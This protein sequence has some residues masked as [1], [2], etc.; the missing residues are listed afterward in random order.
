MLAVADVSSVS[1]SKFLDGVF[2]VG[3]KDG[4]VEMFRKDDDG[5]V[6]RWEGASWNVDGQGVNSISVQ[7][8]Y[9][10]PAVF[11]VLV[12][13]RLFYVDLMDNDVSAGIECGQD[14]GPLRGKIATFATTKG[15]K[16]VGDVWLVFGGEDGVGMRALSDDM[17]QEVSTL[18]DENELEWT[19][20]WLAS[21]VF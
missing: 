14:L 3:R 2:L 1:F 6:M 5:V 19:K 21:A 12:G 18:S 15:S 10:R 4:G 20:L 8:S 13:D 16:R 11:Y 17:V 9:H 7:W